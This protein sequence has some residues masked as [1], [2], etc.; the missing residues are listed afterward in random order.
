MPS[1]AFGEAVVPFKSPEDTS[2][3]TRAR[4]RLLTQ[5]RPRKRNAS[6]QPWTA[7][8]A[9][10]YV[11]ARRGA[12]TASCHGRSPG[13][14]T[15]HQIQPIAHA[16]SR[17]LSRHAPRAGDKGLGRNGIPKPAGAG[18]GSSSLS[19]EPF[20][21]VK[22][23]VRIATSSVKQ[24]GYD[25]GFCRRSRRAIR[26]RRARFGLEKKGLQEGF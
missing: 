1:R 20:E 26:P 15:L 9:C 24:H 16:N 3:G 25:A 10:E 17:A 18:G 5:M 7:N 4:S 22:S 19:L 21:G 12:V 13:T 14:S 2:E 6:A 11:P 8:D 23:K